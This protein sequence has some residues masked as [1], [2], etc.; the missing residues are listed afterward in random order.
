LRLHTGRGLGDLDRPG[1][2]AIDPVA[3]EIVGSGEAEAAVGD[4]ANADAER[5]GV[6][7]AADL[8][9]LGSQRAVA[10]VDNARFGQGCATRPSRFQRL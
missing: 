3:R 6:R 7:C 1:C 8:A 9:V 2:A 5:F 10:L 4:Y